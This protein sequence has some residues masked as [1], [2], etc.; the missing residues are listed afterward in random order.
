MTGS[1]CLCLCAGR[2]RCQCPCSRDSLDDAQCSAD[3][4]TCWLPVAAACL[5]KHA[6]QPA[7]GTHLPNEEGRPLFL[8]FAR[9][10]LQPLTACA[11]CHARLFK[12]RCCGRIS[13]KIF[14][15]RLQGCTL[16][17]GRWM[18]MCASSHLPEVAPAPRD[19]QGWDDAAWKALLPSGALLCPVVRSA[20]PS[21]A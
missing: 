9:R 19:H 4:S 3:D 12:V 20:P 5:Q 13:C 14:S 6:A 18:A 21:A 7:A 17:W 1:S 11:W 10:L 8:H 2:Q 15:A 16:L